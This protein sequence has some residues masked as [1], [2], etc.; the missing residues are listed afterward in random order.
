MKKINITLLWL[1]TIGW[2]M[3]ITIHSAWSA[4]LF[5]QQVVEIVQ[6]SIGN[7]QTT[8]IG[9]KGW[10][11]FLPELQHLVA[12][13]FW[14]ENA[15]KV[16]NISNPDYAD[17]LPA[18][19][20]FKAQLDSV[21]IDLLLV[22]VPAK[23]AIYPEMLVT[24]TDIPIK[25]TEL[26]SLF[27]QHRQFYRLLRQKGV[28]VLD[29]TEVFLDHRSKYQ[30]YCRQDTHW[31]SHACLLAAK[32]IG[33]TIGNPDWRKRAVNQTP[34]RLSTV[35]VEI[36]GDLGV[37]LSPASD[38]EVLTITVVS[39]DNGTTIKPCR[40][41]PVLLLG[42]SHNLVFHAGGDM[43]VQGAGLADHLAHQLGFPIDLVAVRGS[44]ATP[45]RLSLFR[46]RDNLAGKRLV[47]WCFTVREFTEGQGWRKVPVIRPGR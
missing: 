41:S 8:I 13:P 19:L 14:G 10:F 28:Q 42:D 4:D 7:Q 39:Q 11:F 45:A 16:S 6:R 37:S 22:P 36:V 31:S 32:E 33:R 5:H 24:G 38:K 34:Y 27:S 15:K 46:R 21:N 9:R 1:F 29:L 23:A 30:V 26:I 18:I 12:G 47:I 40:K 3:G 25:R 17:P 2:L 43:H 35:Q 20:D 44:G